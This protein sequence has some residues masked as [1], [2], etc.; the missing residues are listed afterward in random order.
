LFPRILEA[1]VQQLTLEFARRG[2]EDLDLFREFAVPFEV[3]VGVID[4]KT[5]AIET[6]EMV[7]ER[8]RKALAFLPKERVVVLPDCGCFHLPR[9]IAFAKLKAMVEGAMIVRKEL[10]N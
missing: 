5:Q 4:V 10:G 6:P 1:N 2:G 9:N 7:A 8:I 3:G